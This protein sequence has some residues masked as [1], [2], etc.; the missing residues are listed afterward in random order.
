MLKKIKYFKKTVYNVNLT[1]FLN[2]TNTE[3]NIVLIFFILA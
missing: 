3:K 1:V 2:V